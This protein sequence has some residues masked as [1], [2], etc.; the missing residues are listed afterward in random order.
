LL[1]ENFDEIYYFLQELAR[2]SNWIKW[3]VKWN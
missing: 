2:K 3:N 1:L